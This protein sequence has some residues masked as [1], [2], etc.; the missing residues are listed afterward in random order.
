MHSQFQLKMDFTDSRIETAQPKQLR[1]SLLKTQIERAG[2]PNGPECQRREYDKQYDRQLVRKLDFS[3]GFT[4]PLSP[5]SAGLNSN[6][7]SPLPHNERRLSSTPGGVGIPNRSSMENHPMAT[8]PAN[9]PPVFPPAVVAGGIPPIRRHAARRSP[10]DGMSDD[11]EYREYRMRKSPHISL[12]LPMDMTDDNSRGHRSQSSQEYADSENDLQMEDIP[13]QM[14]MLTLRESRTPPRTPNSA[15]SMPRM[16][17]T[18]GSKRR[19]SSPQGTRNSRLTISQSEPS[20]FGDTYMRRSPVGNP[21]PP[22]RLSPQSATNKYHAMAG[23]GPSSVL[24]TSNSSGSTA[25]SSMLATP[26][27][28]SAASSISTSDGLPAFSSRDIDMRDDGSPNSLTPRTSVAGTRESSISHGLGNMDTSPDMPTSQR[29]HPMLKFGSTPP[30]L[31]DCCPKKPKRFDNPHDLEQHQSE[32]QHICQY[33][34]NR[35]KNKNEAER[36]QNSLH[37]RKH[38]WSCASLTT[39]TAVFHQ[40]KGCDADICG[41]CGQEF[42]LPADWNARQAH[43]TMEHKFGECNQTKK[44]FRA[45]HF[46]QHLKHSHAGTSGKWTNILENTCMRDE[47]PDTMIS[48]VRETAD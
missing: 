23:R 39:P 27:T 40:N 34:H 38:S 45:D 13:P 36:H 3:P 20:H 31:C 35:F 37:L 19:A 6:P 42:P 44:F 48:P 22:S 4:S 18:A 24:S 33:C 8:N 2:G 25:W 30:Y 10:P 9:W 43:L 26:S 41:Y 5:I 17:Q 21:Y 47:P 1:T 46:R 29:T 16:Q 32:K 12:S 14:N 15:S 11:H 28:F 7:P